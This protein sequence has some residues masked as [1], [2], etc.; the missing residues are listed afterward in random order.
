MPNRPSQPMTL[1]SFSLEGKVSTFLAWARAA[2]RGLPGL[3]GDR[4]RKRTGTRILQSFHS[5]VSPNT[6]SLFYNTDTSLSG[7]AHNSR[8]WI[9][10]SQIPRKLQLSFPF[11]H[12]VRLVGDNT[13]FGS[14]RDPIDKCG[15]EPN[16]LKIIAVECDV[17]SEPSVQKAYD[18]ILETF[19][20]IDA[21]VASA[22][23]P[24]FHLL[25]PLNLLTTH[26]IHRHR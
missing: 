2:L 20:K 7:A 11:S 4:R 8:C 24:D 26:S 19:G 25:Y 23:E 14:N 22:G 18:E 13:D 5:I 1:P 9:S 12:K 6:T 21:V 15:V 16:D 3:Y 17:S 10:D